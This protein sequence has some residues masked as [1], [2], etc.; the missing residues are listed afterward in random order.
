MRDYTRWT[1]TQIQYL[2]EN[3]T[4]TS[5]DELE[6]VL[7][8]KMSA[9]KRQAYK[10]GL[11]RMEFGNRR[12]WLN[13]E[14][15][16]LKESWEWSSKEELEEFLCREWSAI[17]QKA[18][19]L[20][21]PRRKILGKTCIKYTSQIDGEIYR[22]HLRRGYLIYIKKRKQIPVHRTE[23]EKIIGRPLK[24]HEKIHHKN[25]IKHDNRPENLMLFDSQ[26]RHA[27][28]DTNRAETAEQ[29]IRENGLIKLYEVYYENKVGFQLYGNASELK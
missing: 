21:L 13:T 27:H 16:Y 7:H 25:G 10:L 12:V 14:L 2:N 28:I 5:V 24:S 1:E 6:R 4:S 23:M 22:A 26:K 9:I 11:K 15:Q 20:K 19:I 18:H 8:R 3:W 29:F 17:K